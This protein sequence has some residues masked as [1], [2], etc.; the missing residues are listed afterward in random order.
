MLTTIEFD[1]QPL[2]KTDEIDDVSCRSDAVFG[3]CKRSNLTAFGDVSKEVVQ[4]QL[5]FCAMF[6][7]LSNIGK[8]MLLYH[9]GDS[10]PLP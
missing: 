6:A 10:F 4:R 8:I 5:S 9:L 2:F 7:L 3:I 1:D